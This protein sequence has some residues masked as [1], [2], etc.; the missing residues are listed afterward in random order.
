MKGFIIRD[1][2]G[3]LYMSL[4]TFYKK[5]GNWIGGGFVKLNDDDVENSDMIKF[6]DEKPT[7]VELIFKKSD[8]CVKPDTDETI[9]VVGDSFEDNSFFRKISRWFKGHFQ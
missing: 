5:N 8:N 2:D 7:V 3:Q 4:K 6:T 1:E 9:E